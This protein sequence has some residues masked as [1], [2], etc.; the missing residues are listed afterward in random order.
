MGS[1]VKKRQYTLAEIAQHIGATLQGHGDIVVR[2]LATLGGADQDQ[3][4]FLNNSKYTKYLAATKAAAVIC[5]QEHAALCPVNALVLADPYMGYAKAAQLF[6]PSTQRSAG[7]DPTVVV[8]EGC[9]IAATAAIGPRVVLGDGVTVG[10]HTVLHPGV[11]VGD[12]VSIGDHCVLYPNVSLYHD[13]QIGHHVMIHA[14]AVI[15][16][17]GFGMARDPKGVWV[18]IP[19]LGTVEIH[20]H[21]EI[22]A[23]TT[24]DRGAL[25]NTIIGRGAKL[26]NQIQIGHNV[27]IGEH[28][29]MAACTGVSGSAKI[30]KHCIISGM[31]GIAGHIELVDGTVITGMTKVSKS[32]SK[33]GIYSS[34]TTVESH[35]SWL[36]NAVRFKQLD[37]MAQ[38]LADVEKNMKKELEEGCFE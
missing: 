11:V 5:S 20:D 27:V 2:G 4:S 33:P 19:Q 35:R 31:V 21:V 15:G 23:N 6:A 36:K 8:G 22:G 28:T 3:I 24:I 16:S 10:E 18:K 13:V 32:I 12:R 25:E 30:G 38:R 7:I 17:D 34:G 14:G 37:D 1:D 29:A 9:V 26:D